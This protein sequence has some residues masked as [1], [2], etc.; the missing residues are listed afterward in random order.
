MLVRNRQV[1]IGKHFKRDPDR[2]VSKFVFPN[3]PTIRAKVGPKIKSL[4]QMWDNILHF[5]LYPGTQDMHYLCGSYIEN[6]KASFHS[7]HNN[8]VG[9]PLCAYLTTKNPK[10]G[11]RGKQRLLWISLVPKSRSQIP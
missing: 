9:R 5:L 6:L 3:Y 1:Q 8:R 11:N 2:N 4:V 10:T 7:R